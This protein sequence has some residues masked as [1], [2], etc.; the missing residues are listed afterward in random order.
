MRADTEEQRERTERLEG[1]RVRLGTPRETPQICGKMGRPRGKK[2]SEGTEKERD[3]KKQRDRP[4][5]R[6][7]GGGEGEREKEEGSGR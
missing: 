6:L 7:G 3:G 2:V 4:R 5:A 1:L